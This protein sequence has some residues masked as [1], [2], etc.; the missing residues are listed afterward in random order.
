MMFGC[1]PQSKGTRIYAFSHLL[2]FVSFIHVV[3]QTL[4]DLEPQ[5]KL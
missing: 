2:M 3:A 5:K 4:R 1:E